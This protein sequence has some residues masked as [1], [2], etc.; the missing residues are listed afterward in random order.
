MASVLDV[1]DAEVTLTTEPVVRD[2][3]DVFPEDLPGF[4]LHREIDFAIELE[5]GMVPISKASYRMAPI[6]L[7]ELKV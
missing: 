6:K 7:K 4:S 3:L 1:R 5:P 2:H